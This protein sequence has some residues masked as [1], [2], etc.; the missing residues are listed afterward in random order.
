LLIAA[1]PREDD[2]S[3]RITIAIGVLLACFLALVAQSGAGAAERTIR[4]TNPIDWTIVTPFRGALGDDL[5]LRVGQDDLWL[6]GIP[7]A[8]FGERHI[9][10]AHGAVPSAEVIDD[11]LQNGECVSPQFGRFICTLDEAEVVFVREIDPRSG[12]GLPLGIVSA[13]FKAPNYDE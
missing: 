3:R 8:G 1:D 11:V 10:Q 13:Y 6:A 9:V 7:F 12:D 4:N 2:M 5:P